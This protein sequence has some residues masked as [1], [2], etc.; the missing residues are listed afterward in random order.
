MDNTTL[1][2]DDPY[3]FFPDDIRTELFIRIGSHYFKDK[4]WKEWSKATKA[5]VP[6][7]MK[8]SDACGQSFPSQTRIAVYSGITEKS[9]RQGLKGLEDFRDF[10]IKKEITKRGWLKNKYW[11]KPAKR[12]EKG[13]IFISHAF[14]NGG[15]WAL[16][17]S[18]AKA[19]YPVLQYFCFWDFDLYGELE[20]IVES[21]SD[22]VDVYRDRKYDFL[23]AEPEAIAEYSGISERSISSAFQ[24]LMKCYFI[25]SLGTIDNRMTWKLFKQPPRIFNDYLNEQ[26][27]KRYKPKETFTY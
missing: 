6:V 18:C 17:S 26:V 11:L 7:I 24:S 22:F 20:K 12:N 16:L 14:F 5:I 13:A 15:N 27:R 3:D 8:H 23:N 19:I 1:G 10:G 2:I 9:V 21:P 4:I 25:E